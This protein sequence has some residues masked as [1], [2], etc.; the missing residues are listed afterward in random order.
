MEQCYNRGCGQTFDPEKNTDESCC[1]H[2]GAPYFH[3][4][5]KGWSCCKKKS[6][7]FTEFLSMK[8]CTL[9][10]HSNI[11]PPE[12][13][14]PQK[15][16]KNEVIE[17]RPPIRESMQRPPIETPMIHVQPSVAQAVLDAIDSI[18]IQRDR[19][20]EDTALAT[21]AVP[22]GTACK[23][24][25]CT[26]SYNG[27]TADNGECVYH[28]GV[29][30]FHEGMK[31]WSCC[32][33]K[34]SDFSAFMAQKGCACGEH[35]WFKEEDDKQA[36]NCRY[37]WHQTATTVNVS[38]YAKKY[39]YKL[40]KIEVSPIRLHVNLVFPEQ[41]DAQFDLELELRGII[42][43]SKTTA[44]MFGTKVE[45][46]MPKAEPGSWPKLDFPREKLPP[47]RKPNESK[48]ITSNQRKT[49]DSDDGFNLDDIET[50]NMGV[51]LT[52]ISDNKN[53]LD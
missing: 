21:G 51:R 9:S 45:I 27:T 24:K 25:G 12:P 46:I 35:K 41:Q 47:V 23:N 18:Q 38:I 2:P 6:V 48:I 4:A 30:I 7:D 43:V 53:N 52:D 14:K 26:N 5:Y 49:S 44:H 20:S 33:R 17:V 37:D 22:V 39:H 13:E 29:P 28:P 42:D 36:V 16:D 11:K 1:H 19:S 32:Q 3:D 40:S 15:S 34:T 10:K 8:G 50:V 31:Y